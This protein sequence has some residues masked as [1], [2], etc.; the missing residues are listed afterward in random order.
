MHTNGY[1]KR[2]R[3]QTV[4]RLSLTWIQ[5][6]IDITLK[7]P[8]TVILYRFQEQSFGALFI[9]VNVIIEYFVHGNTTI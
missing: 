3:F 4:L 6:L 8:V 7:S 2:M 1:F 9:R 5:H